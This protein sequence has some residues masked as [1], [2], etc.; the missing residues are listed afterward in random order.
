MPALPPITTT[1]CPA[2][3]GSR[4][5]GTGVVALVMVPPVVV[6]PATGHRVAGGACGQRS[7]TVLTHSDRL[8]I[9]A[10]IGL[11]GRGMS[12]ISMRSAITAA[13]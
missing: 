2:S 8:A 11:A 1:V 13:S 5:A 4:W 7:H 12:A 6:V 3:S 9:C 10:S